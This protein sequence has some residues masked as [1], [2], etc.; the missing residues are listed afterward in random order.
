MGVVHKAKD[1]R[2]KR[3]V[4][5]KRLPPELTGDPDAKEH[6]LHEA[7]VA[8]GPQQNNIGILTSRRRESIRAERI[9]V[10]LR[11]FRHS[12]LCGSNTC[13]RACIASLIGEKEAALP[14]LGQAS[15]RG[16]SMKFRCTRDIYFKPLRGY[17]PFVELLQPKG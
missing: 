16:C 12:C 9:S 14:L 3:T 2:L 11:F 6:S 13:W 5:L 1:T 8:S 17:Q 7:Q 15:L 10:S 4:E